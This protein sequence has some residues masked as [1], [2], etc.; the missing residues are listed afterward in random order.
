MDETEEFIQDFFKKEMKRVKED[1]FKLDDKLRKLLE[2]ISKGTP[3]SEFSSADQFK[4]KESA[5]KSPKFAMA[6]RKVQFAC[7]EKI[8]C[9]GWTQLIETVEKKVFPF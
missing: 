9:D 8:R 5:K 2:K 7:R 4:L 3:L 1:K 6:L